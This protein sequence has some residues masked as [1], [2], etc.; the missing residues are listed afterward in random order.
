MKKT[1][2]LLAAAALLAISFSSCRKLMCRC[3]ATGYMS[4]AELQVILNRHINDCV[5]IADD[6][7]AIYDSGAT[8]TCSY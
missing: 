2:A 1:I 8:I 6:G 5:E 3:Q 7:G 4:E